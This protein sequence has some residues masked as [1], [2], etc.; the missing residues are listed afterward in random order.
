MPNFIVNKNAQS[1]G[2]HEVHNLDAGCS[3]LPLPQNQISLGYHHD[4]TSAIRDAK[5]RYPT[6]L[7]DGC[8]YCTP[9]CHTR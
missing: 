5:A 1:D 9:N 4:C 6:H 7:F 2:Y 8:Y 3:F